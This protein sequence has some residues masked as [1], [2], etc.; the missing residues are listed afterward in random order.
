[1]FTKK[2]PD[3]LANTASA[4]DIVNKYADVSTGGEDAYKQNLQA[5]KDHL[6]KAPHQLPLGPEDLDGIEYVYRNFYWFGPAITYNS[7]TNGGGGRGGSMTNYA[8]LMAATDSAGV[9]K[10]YLASEETFAFMKDL[11]TRNLIV[12]LVGNFGGPKA[13]RA[14]GQVRP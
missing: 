13:L 9:V 8:S 3:G 12:P 4:I 2:R 7:S 1:M 11:E 6:T 14:V 10:S 5:I